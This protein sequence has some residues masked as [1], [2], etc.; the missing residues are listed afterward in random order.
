MANDELPNISQY[1]LLNLY[2]EIFGNSSLL[3][4]S[5]FLSSFSYFVNIAKYSHYISQYKFNSLFIIYLIVCHL[6]WL[7]ISV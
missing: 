5:I 7:C 2:Y 6:V 3:L 4:S 1:K